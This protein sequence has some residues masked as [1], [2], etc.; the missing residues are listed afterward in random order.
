MNY[1]SRDEIRLIVNKII[2]DTKSFAPP[3]DVTNIAKTLGVNIIFEE[4]D[5]DVSGFLV[6]KDN[7]ATIAVNNS[8]HSNRQRFT[9]AHELGH[10]S[11][12][13]SEDDND[14]LF[15]DKKIYHRNQ[16]SGTGEFRREI[17]AN[18]F[19]AEILM[20]KDMVVSAEKD[21]GDEIDLSDD[22]NI[23]MLANKFQVSE[24]ALTIRLADLG[25]IQGL[26]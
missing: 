16:A 26:G 7:S 19:A 5:D 23:Y 12:H 6:I 2:V 18:Q 17:E 13:G 21:S 3:I 4:L 8:H 24:Q 10:F 1:Y 11:L 20:P 22:E 14:V 9:I 25:L 15:I